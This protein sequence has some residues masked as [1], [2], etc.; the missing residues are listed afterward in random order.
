AVSDVYQDAFGEGSFIGKGIYDVDAFEKAL[1]E[2][3]PENRILSHDLVEGTYARAGLA[4]DVVLYEE[5]PSSYLA[6][7]ARRQRWIRGDWQIAAWL[8]P[9]V[10]GPVR[11]I[12]NPLSLLSR[13]KIF[14]NLRRSIVPA[15]ELALLALAAGLGVPALAVAAVV[16]VHLVPPVL[17]LLAGVVRGAPPEIPLPVHARHATRSSRGP[18]VQGFFALA[19]LPYEAMYASAAI[20]RTLFR[21]TITRR[22]LL[23]WTTAGEANRSVRTTVVG[24]Y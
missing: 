15:G 21:L 10:P 7:V 12:A 18:I 5:E 22:L 23:E 16:G 8:F 1:G 2:R 11:R 13:W 9:R 17:H 3:F 20:V 6:D 4:T 24:F 19:C 14:D